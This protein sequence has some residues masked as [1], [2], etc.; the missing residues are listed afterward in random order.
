[1]SW[2]YWAPKSTTRTVSGV[3]ATTKVESAGRATGTG[4]GSV[5]HPHSLRALQCFALGLQG[6]G[7]HHLGLLEFLDRLVA[8]R[9]HGRAQRAEE[10]H[11]PVVLVGGPEEDLGERPPYR[12]PH[13]R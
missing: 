4:R 2:A 5:P 11:A 9:G 6:R 1:M 12:R 8:A 3:S 7:H 13:A 10:V